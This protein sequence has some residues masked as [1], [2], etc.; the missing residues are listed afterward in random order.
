VTSGLED[1]QVE[2]D[3]NRCCGAGQCVITAPLLF[4]QREED[5][6]SVVLISHPPESLRADV[7]RAVELCPSR[8]ISIRE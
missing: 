5:G 8:A 7:E 4:D 6:V 2:V 3:Q 1:M